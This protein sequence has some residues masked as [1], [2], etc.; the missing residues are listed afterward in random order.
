M[1]D[2]DVLVRCPDVVA[3][4]FHERFIRLC[5]HLTNLC[6]LATMI[7]LLV[8][9]SHLCELVRLFVH[10]VTIG[11]C[12]GGEEMA[13]EDRKRARSSKKAVRRKKRR[14]VLYHH[15]VTVTVPSYCYSCFSTIQYWYF[16]CTS[17]SFK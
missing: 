1:Y 8:A 3:M 10:L 9:C 6:C 14:Q 17:S 4:V 11:L 5:A 12:T 15:T 7:E 13:Q 16:V 2:F